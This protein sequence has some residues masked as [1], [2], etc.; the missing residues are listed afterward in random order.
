MTYPLREYRSIISRPEKGWNLFEISLHLCRIIEPE[1]EFQSYQA[2]MSEISGQVSTR[3]ADSTHPYDVLN[4]L[5]QVLFEELGFRGN[6]EDYYNP[7]N[8]YITRVLDERKG[9]P[10]TLSILYQEIAA[11]LGIQLLFVGMPGHFLL[12]YEVP[13]KELFIDAF[14]RG[15]M[16]LEEGCRE[17]LE[18][19]YGRELSFHRDFLRVTGKRQT[20]LRMLL[21]LQQIYRSGGNRELLLEVVERRIPLLQDPLPEILE[22]GWIRF[23]LGRYQ[24]AL[25]DLEYF[26]KNTRDARVKRLVEE[27]LEKV[28]ALAEGSELG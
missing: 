28:R 8:S 7:N 2:Y 1:L 11:R 21:N 20:V 22:R 12:K 25:G 17:R 26:V 24:E 6:Q 14:H 10:I 19:V 15:E 5:N 18:Q 23:D 16:L 4:T 9:I 3:L 27:K 13:F